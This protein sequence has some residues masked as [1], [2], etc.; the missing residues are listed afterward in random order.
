MEAVVKCWVISMRFLSQR[1]LSL[2]ST[3]KPMSRD[4]NFICLAEQVLQIL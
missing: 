1:I 4:S 2:Y 3:L